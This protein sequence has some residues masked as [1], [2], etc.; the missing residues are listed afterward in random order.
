MEPHT[1]TVALRV[2]CRCKAKAR[3][4]RLPRDPHTRTRL[5][6]LL[7]WNLDS[8]L[9]TAWYHSVAVQSHRARHQSKQRRR[10]VGVIGRAQNG[11]RDTRCDSVRHL[12]KVRE[13][14]RARS[15]GAACV[16]T[17]ANETVGSTHV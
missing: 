13:Y 17:V 12:A 6:S 11:S 1:I 15:E 2:V 16:C 7:K 3:L 4:R 8:S 5:S 9:Q 14:T 10:W